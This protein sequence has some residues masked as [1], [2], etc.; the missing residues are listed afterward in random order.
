MKNL[1][2]M[3]IVFVTGFGELY[4]QNHLDDKDSSL[5]IICR[6]TKSKQSIV[7]EDFNIND[8]IITHV[9]IGY[10]E[11][12]MLKVF[13]VSTDKKNSQGSSLIQEDFQT[14]TNVPDISYS[15][16]WQYKCGRQEVS[17]M[18]TILES[19]SLK[20]IKFDFSFELEN[21]NDFYCSEFVYEVLHLLDNRKFNF[22]PVQKELSKFYASI[23]KRDFLN[24]IPV[25]F[26]QQYPSFRKVLEQHHN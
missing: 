12:G 25:D 15:S 11:N 5:F 18:I 6:S 7:A 3:L 13:N 2:L 4:A 24:Y 17:H 26:F 23:L 10:Y 1:L 20:S 22:N 9:G 16:V 19:F 14:F 21:G 8:S